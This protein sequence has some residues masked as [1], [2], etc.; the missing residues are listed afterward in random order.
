IIPIAD[1][2]KRYVSGSCPIS[3]L[4]CEFTRELMAID[5]DITCSCVL[6]GYTRDHVELEARIQYKIGRQAEVV[7]QHPPGVLVAYGDGVEIPEEVRPRRS[8]S[9]PATEVAKAS[10]VGDD[11]IGAKPSP[12]EGLLPRIPGM[13]QVPNFVAPDY[14]RVEF[15][16]LHWT[17]KIERLGK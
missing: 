5:K 6:R 1:A 17:V 4:R 2:D 3:D 15:V 7:V 12:E 14:D 16:A 10:S 13:P 9:F 8:Q 11:P